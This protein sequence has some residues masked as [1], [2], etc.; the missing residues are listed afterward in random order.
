MT[1]DDLAAIRARAEAATY[2]GGEMQE[3]AE[4]A[5]AL[6]AEVERLTRENG[7]W[8]TAAADVLDAHDCGEAFDR[9][10][11]EATRL[12]EE[13]E[14]YRAAICFETTCTN[15]AHMINRAAG[16]EAERDALAAKVARVAFLAHQVEEVPVHA[17]GGNLVTRRRMLPEDALN[18]ALADPKDET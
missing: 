15:C 8:R 2:Y 18:A 1:P 4:D 11:R 3:R 16:L 9:A 13:V 17:G 6:L 5:L 7:R 10:A 12:R 14:G